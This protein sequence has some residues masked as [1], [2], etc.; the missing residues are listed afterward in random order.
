MRKNYF[1]KLIKYMENVYHIEHSLSEVVFAKN[2][3][4]IEK[5]IN[6]RY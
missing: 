6:D 4:Q 2:I 3:K 1:T 5:S